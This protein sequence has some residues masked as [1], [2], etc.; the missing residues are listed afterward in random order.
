VDTD[1]RIPVIS[2]LRRRLVIATAVVA[3]AASVVGCTPGPSEPASSGSSSAPPHSSGPTTSPASSPAPTAGPGITAQSIGGHALG[4]ALTVAAKELGAKPDT[5]CPWVYSSRG[6]WQTWLLADA[7]AAEPSDAIVLLAIDSFGLDEHPKD[8]PR[9]A[10]GIGLGSTLDEVKAA[11]P[12]AKPVDA[13][14]VDFA[15]RYT[16]GGGSIVFEGRDDIV[17]SIKVLPAAAENPSEFCG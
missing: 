1:E 7:S 15:L 10:S 2:F 6:A 8:A 9:T 4:S 14:N 3:L 11:Y 5:E 13:I 17:Q 16:E 12:T